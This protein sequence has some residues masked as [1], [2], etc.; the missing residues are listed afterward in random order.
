MA[1]LIEQV[2]AGP[3]NHAC[4]RLA[5][6]RSFTKGHFSP[7]TCAWHCS[8]W[9]TDSPSLSARRM[10]PLTRNRDARQPRCGLSPPIPWPLIIRLHRYAKHKMR[11]VVIDVPWSVYVCLMA[12]TV[13]STNRLRLNPSRCRLGCEL[14]WNQGTILGG[15]PNPPK[16]GSFRSNFWPIVKVR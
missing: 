5:R 7:E 6:F 12:T 8:P 13:N 16:R 15:G 1:E 9:T 2:H 14:G 3:R 4:L 11:H 10:Q